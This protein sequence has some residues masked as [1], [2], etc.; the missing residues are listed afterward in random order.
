MPEIAST[1]SNTIRDGTERSH[2]ALLPHISPLVRNERVKLA[3]TFWN[4]VGAGMRIGGVAGALL[5]K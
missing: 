4:N 3:A 2:A 1:N 5:S